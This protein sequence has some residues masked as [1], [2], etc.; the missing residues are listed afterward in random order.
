MTKD[1]IL[2]P[3]IDLESVRRLQSGDNSSTSS[4]PA[5]LFDEVTKTLGVSKFEKLRVFRTWKELV[6]DAILLLENMTAETYIASRFF[7]PTIS[8]A[9]LRAAARGCRIHVLHSARLDKSTGQQMDEKTLCNP[10]AVRIFQRVVDNPF[11]TLEEVG[12]Y[13][14][15]IVVDASTVCVEIINSEDVSSFFLAV[16]FEDETTAVKLISYFKK[17]EQTGIEDSRKRKKVVAKPVTQNVKV[18][19]FLDSGSRLS[20]LQDMGSITPLKSEKR[21]R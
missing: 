9:G 14:S 4:L 20:T 3:M 10:E 5:Q 21:S 1:V 7:E 8:Q 13:F 16:Q 12:L 18:H 6:D 17:L 2:F 19:R 15:F 11:I